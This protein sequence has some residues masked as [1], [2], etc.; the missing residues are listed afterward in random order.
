MQ[1]ENRKNAKNF[2][3]WRFSR[4]CSKKSAKTVAK[5]TGSRYNNII[6][7]GPVRP[8][9][10]DRSHAHEFLQRSAEAGRGGI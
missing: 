7:F 8:V 3:F 9:Q 2:S 5:P 4:I 10:E 6:I 1:G